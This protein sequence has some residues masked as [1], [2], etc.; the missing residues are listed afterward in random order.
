MSGRMVTL[1]DILESRDRREQQRRTL[2]QTSLL[3][4]LQLSVNIPGSRKNNPMIKEIFREGLNSLSKVL[5]EEIR[6]SH[7]NEELMTGPEGFLLLDL[8]PNRAKGICSALENDH[9]LGRLWDMDVYRSTGELLSRRDLS[10]PSRM[11]YIC[12]RPAHECSRS[13]KH[14]SRQLEEYILNLY[15]VFQSIKS[16]TELK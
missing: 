11:C 6:S 5:K 4:L 16:D 1:K 12:E 7:I 13:G 10:L 2:L 15:R 8:E 3:T 9:I 14:D